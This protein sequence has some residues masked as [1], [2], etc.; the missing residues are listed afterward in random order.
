ML[1]I[2]MFIMVISA[3]LME[4]DLVFI[5]IGLKSVSSQYVV[6]SQSQMRQNKVPLQKSR[7]VLLSRK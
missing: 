4:P 7:Y 1:A 3:I 6:R 5:K 2:V